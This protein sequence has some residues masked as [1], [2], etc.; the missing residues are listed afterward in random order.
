MDW[1]A[2]WGE[3]E[4]GF[5]QDQD[6]HLRELASGPGPCP[7][8]PSGLSWPCPALA[9]G[10]GRP[11]LPL[12]FLGELIS[13]YARFRFGCPDP[14]LVWPALPC[15]LPC[16]CG[17]AAPS[18]LALAAWPPALPCL[19][20]PFFELAGRGRGTGSVRGGTRPWTTGGGWPALAR[21][22]VL[23]WVLRFGRISVSQ[24]SDLGATRFELGR[25]NDC[26][27]VRNKLYGIKLHIR[28]I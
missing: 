18:P 12:P 22:W 19:A 23:L 9:P 26:E 8:L 3:Q 27:C 15:A 11:A 17:E 6:P 5:G 1:L 2:R 7:A 20:L 16:P 25:V 13:V 4:A 10:S 21:P 24:D 28:R 14:A